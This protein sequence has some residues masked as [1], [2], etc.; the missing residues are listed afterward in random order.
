MPLNTRVLQEESEFADK[1]K[2][3]YFRDTWVILL[4]S[5]FSVQEWNKQASR[6][7]L[8]AGLLLFPQNPGGPEQTKKQVAI[9]DGIKHWPG[10]RVRQ[11]DIVLYGM[12]RSVLWGRSNNMKRK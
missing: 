2:Y 4:S 11:T 5:F 1:A 12:Q 6:K 3:E 8:W 10:E 7:I 9:T